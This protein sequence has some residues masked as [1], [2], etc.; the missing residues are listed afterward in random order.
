VAQEAI[1]GEEISTYSVAI[2]GVL[3]AHAAYR[4]LA[5]L[6]GRSAYILA[7]VEA[8]EIEAFSARIAR[9]GDITGQFAFDIIVTAEG[10]LAPIECNPRA[11]S[12]A[13]LMDRDG[14]LGRAL[15]GE[16]PGVLRPD[17]EPR[18][19]A[20]LLLPGLFGALGRDGIGSVLGAARRTADVVS[21]PG[22]LAPLLGA[23]R[24]LLTHQRRARRAGLPLSEALSADIA[25]D[26]R[27]IGAAPQPL[28]QA[29]SRRGGGRR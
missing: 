11:T 29:S 20:P 5:R 4:G 15:L 17:G 1:E 27:P 9:L 3:R 26:G 19:L 18:M 28:A 16:A 14:G 10:R 22:D 21:A 6:K 24:D 25:W 7:P 2:G 23:F 8:P 13:H 12:G